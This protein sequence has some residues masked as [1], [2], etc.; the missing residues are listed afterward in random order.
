[1]IDVVNSNKVFKMNELS[2]DCIRVGSKLETFSNVRSQSKRLK[3]I[4]EI[5]SV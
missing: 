1:M 3:L 4:G 5:S 2:F